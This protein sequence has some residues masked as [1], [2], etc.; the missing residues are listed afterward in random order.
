MAK[1]TLS[2]VTSGNGSSLIST[3][4]ANSALI[5]T[6]MEKTL[7]RDGTSPNEMD[8]DLDMNSQRIINLPEPSSGTEPLRL[9]DYNTALSGGTITAGAP[10]NAHYVTM[11]TNSGLSDERVLTAGDGLTLTDG[12][13]GSTATLA[14]G[15]G[16]GLTVAAD[17]IGLTD[18]TAYTLKGRNAGT[19][20]AASDISITGLTE[21]TSITGN[22]L[23]LIQ[24]SAAS[25]AFKKVK[26]SSLRIPAEYCLYR[27]PGTA[28]VGNTAAVYDWSGTAASANMTKF[29]WDGRIERTANLVQWSVAWTPN[30]AGT[31]DT[32]LELI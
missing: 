4:N 5:E 1:L 11:S 2:D 31:G 19:T 17:A 14:V 21:K 24:D 7:S 9:Q 25:N 32:F 29:W 20:G 15:A 22:D 26:A 27:A 18:M 28:L 16:T 3:I 30:P 23:F 12:G 6:A 10:T 13:A 8:V